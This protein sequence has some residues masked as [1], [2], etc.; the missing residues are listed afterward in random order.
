MACRHVFPCSQQ[1]GIPQGGITMDTTAPRVAGSR[2]K[3]KKGDSDE[4][5]PSILE[6]DSSKEYRKNWARLIQ[7]IYPV[8]C[9][10]AAPFRDFTG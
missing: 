4:P 10:F 5:I 1:G 9:S 6:P 3:R 7:K 2:D 8:K